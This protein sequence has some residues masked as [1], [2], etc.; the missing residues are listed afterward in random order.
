[1]HAI[2]LSL[3]PSSVEVFR[4]SEII[5]QYSLLIFQLHLFL[6]K[7]SL[8]KEFIPRFNLTE[9]AYKYSTPIFKSQVQLLTKQFILFAKLMYK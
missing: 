7:K 9:L 5:Y 6:C 3:M 4:L 2:L 1:M 8:E